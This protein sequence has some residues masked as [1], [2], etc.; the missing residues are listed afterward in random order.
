MPALPGKFMRTIRLLLYESRTSLHLSRRANPPSKMHSILTIDLARDCE[1]VQIPQGTHVTLPKGT[2]VDVTQ[3]LG[4]SYTLH[5]QGGLFRLDGKDADALDL[6]TSP[7]DPKPLSDKPA[8][9]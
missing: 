5:A 6:E 9:L 1:V 8:D 3:Q 2:T 7:A 4:G